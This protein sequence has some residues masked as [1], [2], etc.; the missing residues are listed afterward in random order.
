[1]DNF[2]VPH[3]LTSNTSTTSTSTNTNYSSVVQSTQPK[4]MAATSATHDGSHNSIYEPCMSFWPSST[5]A[6]LTTTNATTPDQ[7]CYPAPRYFPHHD[8][9][10]QFPGGVYPGGAGRHRWGFG[11]RPLVVAGQ[12]SVGAVLVGV[13]EEQERRLLDAWTTKVAR[14]KRRLARQRSLNLITRNCFP[15]SSSI[16]THGAANSSSATT[17]CDSRELPISGAGTR[18][19]YTFCTPD[20]KRLRVLL[21]KELKNSDVGSLGRIVLPKREAEEKLPTLFD[22]EGIQVVMR[23]IYSNREW[24]LRYKYWSNNKS[25]MYV[26]E[27]TGDFV[28]QNGLEIG[29]SITLYEDECKNLG[30]RPAPEPSCKR[31]LITNQ[32]TTV[33]DDK[34]VNSSN[35]TTNDE[36]YDNTN[37]IISKTAHYDGSSSLYASYSY[38]LARDEEDASLALLIEQLNHEEQQ[39]A[40]SLVTTLSSHIEYGTTNASSYSYGH[41]NESST[42]S[43]NHYGVVSGGGMSSTQSTTTIEAVERTPPSSSSSSSVSR[44]EVHEGEDHLEDFFGGLGTLPEVDDQYVYYNYATLFDRIMSD[45]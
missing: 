10:L 19:L 3:F 44:V 32:N 37:N 8:R 28:K 11:Y 34:Y 17:L 30:A 16:A 18:D 5:T 41:S 43:S 33:L 23:D 12:S 24:S 45:N 1:M 42:T 4:L 40:N 20:K 31:H 14:S 7:Y 36:A 2:P 39:E 6:A 9:G 35:S 26:L 27:N 22:K 25:R 38:E 21:K 13:S 15:S 29:D